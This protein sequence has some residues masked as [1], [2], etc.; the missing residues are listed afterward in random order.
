MEGTIETPHQNDILLGR[1]G[2]NNRWIGNEM[3]RNL[4]W[5]R[6][7]EYRTASKKRKAEMSREIVAQVRQMDPPGR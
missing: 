7:E 3:L 1:G 2:N 5:E 6:C 4:A